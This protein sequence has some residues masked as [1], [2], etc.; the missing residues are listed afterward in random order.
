M[1]A[2]I[3]AQQPRVQVARFSRV[4]TSI[5]EPLWEMALT[6]LCCQINA[7]TS[8]N[9]ANVK[10]FYG[11]DIFSFSAGGSPYK[12]NSVTI[13]P[14]HRDSTG[15]VAWT[16]TVTKTTLNA[17]VF[18][19]ASTD[20][21]IA[22]KANSACTVGRYSW[23]ADYLP[24]DE[25]AATD[26]VG[27]QQAATLMIKMTNIHPTIHGA[28]GEGGFKCKPNTEIPV[29]LWSS[30]K[31][32]AD[33]NDRIVAFNNKY[34]DTEGI[35]IKPV[36]A[37]RNGNG[38]ASGGK[39]S[40]DWWVNGILVFNV[41][42]R[43]H[44]RDDAANT[45]FK[46]TR[47]YNSMTT[48]E[49]WI[50]AK[51]FVKHHKAEL[52][53]AFAAYDGFENVS[54]VTDPWGDPVV[55]DQLYIRETVHM[56][57]VSSNRAHGT[58]NTNYQITANEALDAGTSPTT[59]LDKGNYATRIGLAKYGCDIHPYQPSDYMNKE[60][61][62]YICGLESAKRMWN[63]YAD[64]PKNPLY[65]PYEVLRTSYVSN[66]LIPGYAAGVCSYSWGEVRV[67]SNLSV[68]GDAAGIAAGYCCNNSMLP[69][70]VQQS[71]TAI[72]AIQNKIVAAHGRINK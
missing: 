57:M 64:N 65:V 38:T 6:A 52:E 51:N 63:K 67:F 37:A 33:P 39:L 16:N 28:S 31:I 18:I 35:M 3:K 40:D 71:T 11:Q 9:N 72:A 59:G 29:D 69:Y 27:R 62:K 34:K 17:T 66:L 43:S 32:Y 53:R 22:R 20:G 61:T 5:T 48:D 4:R 60:G 12:I 49:A 25:R 47:K 14:I 26:Y 56:S 2:D 15:N 8:M 46:V 55:G 7:K 10:V 54:I 24:T 36:N 1:I 70:V 44:Y 41:D 30:S 19:D 23:P 13:S 21:R 58:Y 68:L 50:K 45:T 42:G